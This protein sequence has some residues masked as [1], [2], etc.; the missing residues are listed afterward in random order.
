M[1]E[2]MDELKGNLKEGFGKVSGD[3]RMA[4]EGKGQ[5]TAAK[6][7][8]ETKGALEEAGGALKQGAGEVFGSERLEAEGKADRLKGQT[9][10]AG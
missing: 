4:G 8:R 10:Q 5:A 9:R 6:A 2:R 3:E 7:S 1:G